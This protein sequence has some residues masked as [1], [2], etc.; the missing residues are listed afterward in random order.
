LP[1]GARPEP[2]W[3]WKPNVEPPGDREHQ[4]LVQRTTTPRPP[5]LRVGRTTPL[6][7]P[8]LTDEAC[9]AK[10]RA[11]PRQVCPDANRGPDALRSDGSSDDA[12]RATRRARKVE[13]RS[14]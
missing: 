2:R 7:V 9:V 8:K 12:T 13:V 10:N 14:S 11:A 1:S 6:A 5:G 3:V 4:S